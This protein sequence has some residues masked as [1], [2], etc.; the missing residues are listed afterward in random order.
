MVKKQL[1]NSDMVELG[2]NYRLSDVACALGL[3]Q[4]K[5]LDSFMEKRSE[6]AKYYD[7]RFEKNPYFSTIKINEGCTSSRHLYPILLFP[8]FWCPKEDIFKALQEKGVGVQVH[9]KPT[10]KFT[11]YQKLFG[12]QSLR[13]AEDFY[14]A[15]LSIPCHQGMRM[16]DAAYVADTLME[17]LKSY[18]KGCRV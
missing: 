1:W 6:I 18:E 16:E 3:S 12:E 4:L 14:K 17:T 13:N 15:E 7:E 8:E 2:Y 5:R 11:Y 9:Y 10:Y